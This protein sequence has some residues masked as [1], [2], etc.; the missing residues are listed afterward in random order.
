M[1]DFRI[2][3]RITM[4][5]RSVTLHDGVFDLFTLGIVNV[6]EFRSVANALQE[7]CFPSV[8]SADDKDSEMTNAIEVL[9]DYFRTQMHCLPGHFFD[10]WRDVWH[11][12]CI[13]F[14]GTGR[15]V[16]HHICAVHSFDTSGRVVWYHVCIHWIDHDQGRSLTTTHSF[17]CMAEPRKTCG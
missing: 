4:H 17:S 11:H 7:R 3:L 5:Q 10:D 1:H 6:G 2:K 12:I 16:W 14:F 15:D 13:R 9:F 8:R